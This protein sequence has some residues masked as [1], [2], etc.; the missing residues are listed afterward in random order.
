MPSVSF[1][2]VARQKTTRMG[3][4]TIQK[5]GWDTT[6]RKKIQHAPKTAARATHRL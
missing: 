5:E 3:K 6:D 1:L 4:N 2:P